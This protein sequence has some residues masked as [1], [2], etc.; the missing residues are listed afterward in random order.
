LLPSLIGAKN[1]WGGSGIH[2]KSFKLTKNVTSDFKIGP[3]T[4]ENVSYHI[5]S[6]ETPLS[7]HYSI[8]GYDV[9]KHFIVTLDLVNNNLYLST[10]G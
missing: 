5:A 6:K 10:S 3:Y 2:Q 1:R 8:L 4:L 9:L 7:G